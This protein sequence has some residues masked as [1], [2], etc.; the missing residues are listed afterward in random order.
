MAGDFNGWDPA[1]TPLQE[2]ASG[3]WT[4]TIPLEPGRY[5]YMFVVDGQQWI[6]DIGDV[7]HAAGLVAQ[8]AQPALEHVVADV[9]GGV[10]QV[11]GV[12]GRDPAGVHEDDVADLERDDG[13]TGRVVEL[14]HRRKGT[15]RP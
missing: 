2:A 13:P 10:T 1:R 15:A 9:D 5:K 8:V 6:V 4:V 3:S 14:H 12:V 7:A 11:G